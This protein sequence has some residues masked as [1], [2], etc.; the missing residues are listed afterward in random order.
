MSRWRQLQAV[1][2]DPDASE[3]RKGGDHWASA[4]DFGQEFHGL[5]FIKAAHAEAGAVDCSA[6]GWISPL[7]LPCLSRLGFVLLSARRHQAPRQFLCSDKSLFPLADNDVGACE[8]IAMAN[9]TNH[10]IRFGTCRVACTDT[11]NWQPCFKHHWVVSEVHRPHLIWADQASEV[12]DLLHQS[13]ALQVDS[14]LLD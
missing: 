7:L 3:H 12:V 2:R 14:V 4:K 9:R 5:A 8:H 13:I 10:L 1:S 6:G 11:F